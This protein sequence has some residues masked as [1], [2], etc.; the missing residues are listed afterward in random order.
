MKMRK[1][2]NETQTEVE[3]CED[4]LLAAL[5]SSSVWL[6]QFMLAVI[7]ITIANEHSWHCK[8]THPEGMVSDGTHWSGV[9]A[10]NVSSG[11]LLSFGGSSSASFHQT[12]P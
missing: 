3:S 6:A 5:I 8:C 12:L 1:I 2:G 9:K 11:N 4:L 10:Q 7:L